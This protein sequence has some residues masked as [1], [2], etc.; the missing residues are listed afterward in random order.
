[1]GQGKRTSTRVDRYLQTQELRHMYVSYDLFHLT[2][3]LSRLRLSLYQPVL[4]QR[5]FKR[6]FP[7][8]TPPEWAGRFSCHSAHSVSIPQKLFKDV[9]K[10]WQLPKTSFE[11]QTPSKQSFIIH[12]VSTANFRPSPFSPA[13][14]I[15][16]HLQLGYQASFKGAP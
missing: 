2:A 3:N 4:P 16:L 13:S 8:H 5:R 11:P 14:A 9:A 6:S 7:L 15:H 12:F 10:R 1:M